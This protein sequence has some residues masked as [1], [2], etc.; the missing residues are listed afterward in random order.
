MVCACGKEFT[1]I[2]TSPWTSCTIVDGKVISGICQ[3]GKV[4]PSIRQ[5]TYKEYVDHLKEI[6]PE[7][8]QI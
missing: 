2:S 6:T 7:E 5:A 3:H 1:S 4:F 8:N